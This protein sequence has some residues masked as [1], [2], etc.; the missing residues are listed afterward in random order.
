M[1]IQQILEKVQLE[2]KPGHTSLRSA[3]WLQSDFFADVWHLNFEKKKIIVDWRVMLDGDL[4]SSPRHTQTLFAMK[5]WLLLQTHNTLCP[6]L[7][8]PATAIRRV[9]LILHILNYFL[10]HE[11]KIGFGR[12]GFMALNEND[13]KN[14]FLAI[15][16]DCRDSESI[17]QWRARM[18]EFLFA[19]PEVEENDIELLKSSAPFLFELEIPKADWTS[20]FSIEQLIRARIY[21][22]QAG[23]YQKSGEG[24]SY[25]P[26]KMKIAE[27]IYPH[28]LCRP[29]SHLDFEELNLNKIESY[30]REFPAIGV[31]TCE[32]DGT[33]AVR[34]SAYI[35][36]FFSLCLLKKFDCDVPAEM[37]NSIDQSTLIDLNNLKSP[38]RFRTLPF[39]VPMKALK[40]GVEFFYEEAEHLTTSYLNIVSAATKEKLNVGKFIE[41][42]GVIDLL[43]PRT[44]KFGCRAWSV[45]SHFDPKFHR[46]QFDQRL[47][48]PTSDYFAALRKNVGLVDLLHVLYGSCQSVIGVMMARRNGELMDLIAGQALSADEQDMAFFNRKTGIVDFRQIALRPIPTVGKDIVKFITNFQEKMVA[49]SHLQR[50]TALFALPLVSGKLSARFYYYSAAFDIFCDYFEMPTNEGKRYYIRQHQLRRVFALA[51]LHAAGGDAQTLRWFLGHLDCEHLW[52]YIT[53]ATPGD[54]LRYVE[55]YFVSEKLQTS[56]GGLAADAALE[57]DRSTDRQLRDLVYERFETSN[58][59]LIDTDSLSDFIAV[60]MMQGLTIQPHFYESAEGKSYRILVHFKENL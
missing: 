49:E 47:R 8:R 38:G 29:R 5:N 17:Y 24:S 14:F 33:M 51:F 30:R 6:K 50:L 26:N 46:V 28:L 40:N 35:R 57:V 45:A 21:L 11:S 10:L 54:V 37:L 60:Q 7:L 55:A 27:K 20:G 48:V 32:E 2:I 34:T 12:R 39:H 41:L 25:I 22:W 18:I 52:H 13:V 59:A 1:L 4:L 31:H 19:A 43:E 53:D 3:S 56:S 16:R 9:R 23:L 42:H 15:E 44:R 36:V 58:Y